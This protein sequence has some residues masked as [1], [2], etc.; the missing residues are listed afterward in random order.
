MSEH[1]RRAAAGFPDNIRGKSI[2]LSSSECEDHTRFNHQCTCCTV[3]VSDFA[4]CGS[5]SPAKHDRQEIIK[6]CFAGRKC[7]QASHTVGKQC[8]RAASFESAAISPPCPLLLLF[9]VIYEVVHAVTL[10]A[11]TVVFF[12]TNGKCAETCFAGNKVRCSSN[13]LQCLAHWFG[14]LL[15]VAGAP[16]KLVPC[17]CVHDVTDQH[18][19]CAAP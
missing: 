3:S 1:L 17:I 10:R 4:A 5:S 14:L 6:A 13:L 12:L 7:L 16:Q 9:R 19:A 2:V 11:I 8:K 18:G 15:P